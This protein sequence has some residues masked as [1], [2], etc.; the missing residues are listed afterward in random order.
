MP[1]LGRGSSSAEWFYTELARQDIQLERVPKPLPYAKPTEEE[2]KK[3]QKF[4]EELF[5][6]IDIDLTKPE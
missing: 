1:K 2:L 6:G 5:P 4:L 3:R